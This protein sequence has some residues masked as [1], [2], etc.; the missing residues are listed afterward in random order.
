M[1]KLLLVV[2]SAPLLSGC[3]GLG[4][5]LLDAGGA[6]GGG[7]IANKL[8][9][10]NP[11]IT[12]AGAA[13]GVLLTEGGQALA[14]SSQKKASQEGLET[15]RAQAAKEYYWSLQDRQRVPRGQ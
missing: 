13:G 15:G 7:L 9:H 12:A 2:L 14:S 10:G 1:K 3:S 11:L 8:S 4:R 5:G 6:A